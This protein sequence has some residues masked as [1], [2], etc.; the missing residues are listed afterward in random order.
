MLRAQLADLQPEEPVVDPA[1]HGT[2]L[3]AIAAMRIEIVDVRAKFKYGGNVDVAHRE[4][5]AARLSERDVPGDAA[6]LT[7]LRRR[8]DP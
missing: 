5:V 3:K 8:M 6:A 2:R 4:A 1:E 7:H